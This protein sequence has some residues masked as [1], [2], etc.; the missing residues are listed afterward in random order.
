MARLLILAGVVLVAVGLL[1]KAGVPFGRLPGDI[2]IRRGGAT[3]YFPI[4]TC[5]VV[6]VVL[7]LI[8]WIFRR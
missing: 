6:S 1:V 2:V 8:G 5:I 3:F 4:V 7:S